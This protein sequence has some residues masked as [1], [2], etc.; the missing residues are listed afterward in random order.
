MQLECTKLHH[1]N[2]MYP[3]TVERGTARA[4]CRRRALEVGQ[5][6][7]PA[8]PWLD[9][10]GQALA[11]DLARAGV[12]DATEPSGLDMEGDHAP[13]PGQV[14]QGAPVTAVHPSRDQAA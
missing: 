14:G 11:E 4:A 13:L 7:R 10:F 9:D 3:T 8:R 1:R 5:P 2:C 12:R 6:R